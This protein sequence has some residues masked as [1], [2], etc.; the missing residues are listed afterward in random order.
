MDS[1]CGFLLGIQ[2]LFPYISSI[3]ARLKCLL[4]KQRIKLHQTLDKII[5]RLMC[6]T[7]QNFHK[8]QDEVSTAPEYALHSFRSTA[9][10][11]PHPDL[12]TNISVQDTPNSKHVQS[13]VFVNLLKIVCQMKYMP[14]VLDCALY[15][16][17]LVTKWFTLQ[18]YE[19]IPM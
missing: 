2:F 16:L 13:F 18:I 1:F 17:H 12:H 6:L 10:G 19:C 14:R 3:I 9:R 7:N 8:M 5:N 15:C 4:Q 11:R